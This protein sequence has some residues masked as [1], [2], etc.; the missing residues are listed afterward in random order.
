MADII[1]LAVMASI[2]FAAA[3]AGIIAE[4]IVNGVRER[5]KLE[6][7]FGIDLRDRKALAAKRHAQLG[8]G[9]TTAGA[10]LGILATMMPQLVA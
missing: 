2:G 1:A 10:I 8:L 7:V 4:P 6:R 3:G 9:V 5:T